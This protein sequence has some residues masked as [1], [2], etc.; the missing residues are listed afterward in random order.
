[1]LK[2]RKNMLKLEN[3][4]Q[5]LITAT[6]KLLKKHFK[7]SFVAQQPIIIVGLSGGPDS[8]FLLYL[9]NQ[10]SQN[11]SIKLV[12]AHLD[13]GWR[14][15]SAHDVAWCKQL[16]DTLNIEFHAEHARNIDQAIKTNGSQ[17]ALGRQLRRTFFK[18]LSHELNADLVALGHHADD[19]QETFFLRLIRG[20]SLSGLRCMDTFSSNYFRPLLKTSKKFILEYLDTS[21]ISYL[22]DPTN[23]SPNYLRNRIRH[24]VLPALQACDERFDKKLESTIEHLRD[25]DNFLQELTKESFEKIFIHDLKKS[26]LL[27]NLKYFKTLHPVLQKRVL[28]YWL[29]QLKTHFTPQH[30]FLLELLKF[31]NSPHGGTHH[32][33]DTWLIKK[34]ANLFWITTKNITSKPDSH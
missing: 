16:C 1:M 2:N 4:F 15:D 3:E 33:H 25:E 19:Q 26:L 31:L 32:M 8:V 27:G 24:Q 5:P 29:I 6:K 14:A 23:E 30:S 7:Q 34:Q 17:E 22:T 11:N 12:A 20:T 18:K 9:L 13:H 28:I 10:L 21:N